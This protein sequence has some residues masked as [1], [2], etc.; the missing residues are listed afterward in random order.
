MDSYIYIYTYIYIYLNLYI[1]IYI[2]R[3]Q[4]SASS[5]SCLYRDCRQREEARQPSYTYIYTCIYIYLY[6]YI[7]K[8]IKLAQLPVE[9]LQADREEAS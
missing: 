3:S 2:C 4:P 7:Y 1:H 6:I 5:P 8:N 9:R